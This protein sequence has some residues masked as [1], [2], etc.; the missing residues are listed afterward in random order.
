MKKLAVALALLLA[1]PACGESPEDIRDVVEAAAT[2]APVMRSLPR[3]PHQAEA[4]ALVWG[5]IYGMANHHAPP[6]QWI[7]GAGLDCPG[8]R[9]WIGNDPNSCVY[10]FTFETGF[11]QVAWWSDTIHRTAFSHEL[12]HRKDQVLGIAEGADDHSSQCF[13]T[14]VWSA[15]RALVDRGW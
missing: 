1:L 14:E 6:I 8:G 2:S 13:T 4:M 11:V 12:C 10:G 5:E 15:Q 3:K 9:G 7:E